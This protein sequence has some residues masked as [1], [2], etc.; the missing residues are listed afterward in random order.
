MKATMMMHAKYFF[1]HEEKTFGIVIVICIAMGV[2][3]IVFLGYHL[4]LVRSNVTTNEQF[5][6]KEIEKK[7]YMEESVI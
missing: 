7:L 3:L 1:L 5:K 2:V 6:R 4:Y